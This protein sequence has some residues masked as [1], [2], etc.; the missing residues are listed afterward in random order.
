M[1]PF[2]TITILLFTVLVTVLFSS[3]ACEIEQPLRLDKNDKKTIDTLY[4]EQ[5]AGLR[6][7]L[8]SICQ[9]EYDSLIRLEVDSI[10]NIRL[11]E[12]KRQRERFEKRQKNSK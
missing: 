7:V 5:S 8:D 4:L 6:K 11:E 9:T 3:T 1:K 12:I 2:H 10:L